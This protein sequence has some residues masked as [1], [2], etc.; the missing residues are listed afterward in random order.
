MD[1]YH[2]SYFPTSLANCVALMNVTIAVG[3]KF[4][5]KDIRIHSFD[6]TGNKE[7]KFIRFYHI[8]CLLLIYGVS[9]DICHV[10]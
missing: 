8:K 7:Y 2:V 3:E 6:V 4:L 10:S 1:D 5:Y 9:E